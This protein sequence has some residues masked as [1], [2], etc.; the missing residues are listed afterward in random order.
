[1]SATR[2]QLLLDLHRDAPR[3]LD[4]FVPGSNLELIGRI[5][6]L[7]TPSTGDRLYIWGAAGCGRSHL[8]EAAEHAAEAVRPV[9]RLSAAKIDAEIDLRPSTLLIVDDVERLSEAAQIAL[10]RRFNDT[11]ALNLALLL[12][13]SLPPGELVLREDLR[14]RIGQ[15][16]VYEIKPLSDA[17][18]AA[19]LACFAAGRNMRLDDSVVLYLLRHGRRDLPSLLEAIAALDRASL[20]QKRP[21]TLPLLREIMQS[22]I[23]FH[24]FP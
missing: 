3:T 6:A 17:E 18:K 14:T 19:A 23:E 22:T 11:L 7:A 8:L 21:A 20:E 1:M 10:F 13:G 2:R 24:C 4:N 15:C 5:E 12:A 16:L 9:L